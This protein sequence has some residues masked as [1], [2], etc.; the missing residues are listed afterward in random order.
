M[1]RLNLNGA[2]V[3][4]V[5]LAQMATILEQYGE[6][7]VTGAHVDPN[8]AGRGALELGKSF[9]G[10]L[11]DRD[12]IK[13][14]IEYLMGETWWNLNRHLP[15][16]A[17][18]DVFTTDA[19]AMIAEVQPPST[20]RPR[21]TETLQ[22]QSAPPTEQVYS[23]AKRI[24]LDLEKLPLHTHGAI[25]S[26]VTTM[27]KHREAN[28]QMEQHQAQ[29]KAQEAAMADA[30]KAHAVA[31]AERDAKIA[32]QLVSHAEEKLPRMAVVL[33]KGKLVEESVTQ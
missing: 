12:A 14:K 24:S 21:M 29:L 9:A 6:I 11:Q 31:Q 18:F 23:I 15:F 27:A 2:R 28:M 3:G 20:R 8:G 1:K 5:H 19:L 32:A 4:P 33:D 16:I 22:N 13:A 30:R 7:L 25:I 17:L 10:Y 26:L